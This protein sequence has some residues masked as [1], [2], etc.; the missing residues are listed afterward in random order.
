MIRPAFPG[1]RALV[2]ACGLLLSLLAAA[3]GT[4]QTGTS[5]V[6]GTV[7][8]PQGNVVA[9]ASVTLTNTETNAARTQPTNESGQFVFDLIPPGNYRLEVEGAGF[10]KAALT[11]VR[12]FVAKPT[13]L[14]VA[15]E[16]GSVTETVT[17]AASSAEVLLNTQDATL[18]HN[19]VSQQITQL[20]LEARNPVSLRHNGRPRERGQ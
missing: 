1:G 14:A 6:R 11:D 10:K 16:I 13:E 9:G 20:P 12:A 19:F 3:P 17:V 18:G 4:A 7:A 2:L 15:L 8:D 5:S